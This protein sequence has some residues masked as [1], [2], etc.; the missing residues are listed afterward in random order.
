MI[1]CEVVGCSKRQGE[2]YACTKVLFV[3]RP[4]LLIVAVN[5]KHIVTKT[6]LDHTLVVCSKHFCSL[7]PF[8]VYCQL[9]FFLFYTNETRNDIKVFVLDF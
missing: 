5:R 2:E 6:R 4:R 3:E 1:D 9:C 8:N 7:S